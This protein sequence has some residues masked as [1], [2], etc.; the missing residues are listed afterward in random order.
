VAD[1]ILHRHVDLGDL[2]EVAAP[3]GAFTM[4]SG[5]T[6]PIVLLSGGVGVTPVLA[7]LDSLVSE[8]TSR[9]VW[10]LHAARCGAEHAFA[11]EARALIARLRH[12]HLHVRYSRP[13][14][15]DALGRDCDAPG[16]LSVDAVAPRAGRRAPEFFLCGPPGFMSELLAGLI[17]WGRAGART[18]RA[19]RT[20]R[21]SGSGGGVRPPSPCPHQPAGPP[22]TGPEVAFTRSGLTV[23][24]DDRFDSLLEFAEACDVPAGCSCRMGVCHTCECG[25]VDGEVLT[26]LDRSRRRRTATRGPAA[27]AQAA[28]SPSSSE[29]LAMRARSSVRR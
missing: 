5:A 19:F 14:P 9:E 13:A 2:V 16:H 15:G 7:M 8:R 28:M 22:G 17:A 24:W 1:E 26:T 4:P 18:H 10:W 6:G 11:G 27:H 20:L 23:R 21:R 3:R 25:L 29:G 12:G